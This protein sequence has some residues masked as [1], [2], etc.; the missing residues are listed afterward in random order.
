MAEYFDADDSGGVTNRDSQRSTST[1]PTKDDGMEQ[2]EV[3]N[4]CS[5]ST[6]T[7]FIRQI[8]TGQESTAR[9]RRDQTGQY[10]IYNSSPLCWEMQEEH[11][12]QPMVTPRE[13]PAVVPGADGIP[14][15]LPEPEEQEGA[16]GKDSVGSTVDT[17]GRLAQLRVPAGESKEAGGHTFGHGSLHG[18]GTTAS[19]TE[20]TKSRSQSSCDVDKESILPGGAAKVVAEVGVHASR[21][22]ILWRSHIKL[23]E[24]THY[25][26]WVA[27][28]SSG[29]WAWDV[30]VCR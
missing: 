30:T 7:A 23:A 2:L 11:D 20:K 19:G 3:R 25:V 27:D 4:S 15:P 17:D 26:S 29:C 21:W 5:R 18:N 8:L 1:S 13:A 9:F 6:H 22:P 12:D 24:S 10:R 16:D 14:L 28:D